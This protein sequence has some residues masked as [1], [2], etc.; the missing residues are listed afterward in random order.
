MRVACLQVPHFSLAVCLRAEPELR[1]T[2]VVVTEGEGPRA[3]V[4]AC[5]AEA[6]SYGVS[7]GLST[8]Q[9]RNVYDGLSFRS[10]SADAMRAA[11]AALCD[12]AYAHSPRIEEG[13][14]GQEGVVFLEIGGLQAL[15][16]SEVELVKSLVRRANEVGF[17]VTV[18][19]ASTKVAAHLA[20]ANGSGRAIIP[21]R[22]EWSFLAPLPVAMLEPGDQL[23]E[24]LT[25]WGIRTLGDLAALPSSA[26]ATRLG[27][28]GAQ[29]VR[30]ARGEDE[31][32]FVTRVVPLAFEEVS[33]VD[34]GIETIEPFLFV[35]RPMIER[36][37]ARL[38][39][40]GLVCGDLHLSLGLANRGRDERTVAVAAPSREVKPLL[41]LL[42][43]HLEAH[44]P[45]APVERI[46]VVA[47]AEQLRPTQLDLLRPNGPAPEKLAITLAKLTALCGAA[48]RVGAPVVA[49]S[50]CP[51][52]YGVREFRVPAHSPP[53]GEEGDAPCL[54]LRA[55]RPPGE[56]EVFEDRG[57]L[58]FVR[59][60]ENG[61]RSVPRCQGRVVMS[62]GP[63]RVQ[64][65]WWKD[66]SYHRD[67]Y[68]VQLSDGGV[69]RLFYEPAQAKW[70]V[71]GYYD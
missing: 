71:D 9:A 59:P 63:W 60:S 24:T 39:V 11:Q 51:D 29:L 12:V 16:E 3:P 70:F 43:L 57:R 27:P 1:G 58:D 13:G 17:E 25:R 2:G 4:V 35:V 68:D 62:A 21:P 19:V 40:R 48:D 55:V 54:A 45:P 67:Y 66:E 47:V 46:V 5:S 8:A 20:A 56:L 26:V 50:H 22:E 38:A 65:E 7:L 64:G 33:E 34:Y 14:P 23:R 52:A 61:A 31:K 42:R 6:E 28:Q 32:P 36:L 41:V 49:D 37:M 10:V 69:Y 53:G 15:Y 30:R 44:P 18:G